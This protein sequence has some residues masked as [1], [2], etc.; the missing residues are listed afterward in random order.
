MISLPWLQVSELEAERGDLSSQLESTKKQ[1]DDIHKELTSA[2]SKFKEA[3]SQIDMLDKEKGV[4]LRDN[5]A[6][7]EQFIQLQTQVS[8]GW[9]WLTGHWVV[10]R[11]F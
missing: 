9:V 7:Y 3:Q 11:T 1:C 2:S 4:A 8:L 6:S 5:A 10:G